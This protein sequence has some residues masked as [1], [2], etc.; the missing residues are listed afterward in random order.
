LNVKEGMQFYISSDGYQ[1]QAGGEK[2]FP[3]GKNHFKDI[4]SNHFNKSQSDQKQIF[5][6]TLAAYQA[7]KEQVDDITLIG[8]KI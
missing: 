3:F 8:F 4:I 6:N 7:D 1:D 2:G 5:I